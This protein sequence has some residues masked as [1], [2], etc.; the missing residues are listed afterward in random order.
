MALLHKS[1]MKAA[2]VR[3]AEYPLLLPMPKPD[4]RKYRT[5]NWKDYN[6]ALKSRGDLLISIDKDRAWFTG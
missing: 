3:H 1:G 5:T 4:P 2:W 6:A